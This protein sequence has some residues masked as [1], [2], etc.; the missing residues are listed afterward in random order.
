MVFYCRSCASSSHLGT[1]FVNGWLEE[2]VGGKLAIAE[3]PRGSTKVTRAPCTGWGNEQIQSVCRDHGAVAAGSLLS[4]D[5]LG[6]NM[7]S[8]ST[9]QPV[10][11]LFADRAFSAC[12]HLVKLLLNPIR[13]PREVL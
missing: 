2:G 13:L 3:T 12:G 5:P 8:P 9:E 4:A 10:S 6:N 7:Q 11:F 1:D